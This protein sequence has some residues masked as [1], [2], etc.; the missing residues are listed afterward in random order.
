MTHRDNMRNDTYNNI[1]FINELL[2]NMHIQSELSMRKFVAQLKAD[3]Y[4]L[5]DGNR[6]GTGLAATLKRDPSLLVS[7]EKVKPY[8]YAGKCLVCLV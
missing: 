6:Y 4:C 2:L 7:K 3:G 8:K 5:K 1:D